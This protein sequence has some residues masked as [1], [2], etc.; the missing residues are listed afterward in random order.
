MADNFLLYF[1]PACIETYLGTLVAG[2]GGSPNMVSG[3][4]IAI[5]KIVYEYRGKY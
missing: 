5:A 1:S 4:V 2:F 3:T